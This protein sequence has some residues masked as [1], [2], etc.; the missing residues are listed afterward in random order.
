M[1]LAP[2]VA[3][4]VRVGRLLDPKELQPIFSDV[5]IAFDADQEIFEVTEIVKR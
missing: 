2:D 4:R 1:R 5:G 3:G